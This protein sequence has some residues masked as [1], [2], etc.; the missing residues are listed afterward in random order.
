MTSPPVGYHC[1]G[2]NH[3]GIVVPDLA[4]AMAEYGAAYDLSWAEPQV[5]STTM[6]FGDRRTEMAIRLVWSH[7][8]PTHFELIEEQPGTLWTREHG[9]PIHHIGYWAVDLAAAAEAL[10]H[11]GHSLEVTRDDGTDRV[12]RF[13][14]LRAPDGFRVEIMDVSIKAGYDAYLSADASLPSASGK[15]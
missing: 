13:A 15:H 6:R 4:A 1:S 14:Y 3:F 8:G 7:Q 12:S 2:A 9:A 11:R 10:Q 5:R